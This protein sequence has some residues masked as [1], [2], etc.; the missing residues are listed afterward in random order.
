MVKDTTNKMAQKSKITRLTEF[1]YE[2]GTLR[3]VPRSHAQTLLSNDET[4]NIASHSF[5]V[6]MI[7]WF[8]AKQEKGDPYKVL[9]MCLFH[10]TPE[11][12]SGDQNWVHKKYVK[13]FEKEILGAQLSGLPEESEL[14]GIAQEYS[15]RKTKEAIVAKDADLL[16]QI[17]LLREYAWAGNNEAASWLGKRPEK[18]NAQFRLLKT[19]TAR[20]LAREIFRQRP[21]CW[22]DN[23]WTE[24][25]R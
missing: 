13:V 21:S 7:G 6:A 5:R 16:D 19:A 18:Y 3:K 9:L 23:V 15:K 25:R 22:W 10:D 17:L 4:D 8:I 20:K 2:V 11:T 1:F 14:K 12:R 24:K